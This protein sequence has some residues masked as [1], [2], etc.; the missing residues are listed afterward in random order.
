MS[1]VVRAWVAAT[2]VLAVGVVVA[3]SLTSFASAEDA[4]TFL[5]TF[6]ALAVGLGGLTAV[7]RAERTLGRIQTAERQLPAPDIGVLI[8]S[9]ADERT[10][11]SVARQVQAELLPSRSERKRTSGRSGSFSVLFKGFGLGRSS[12]R[13]AEDTEVFENTDDTNVLLGRVLR[14]LN[15]KKTLRRDLVR[16]PGLA[17][18]PDDRF[19][20]S[21]AIAAI[22]ENFVRSQAERGNVLGDNLRAGSMVFQPS[23]GDDSEKPDR[24][25]SLTRALVINYDRFGEELSE[26][27]GREVPLQRVADSLRHRWSQL[28]DGTLV[29]VEG[30]WDIKQTD[31][32][33]LLELAALTVDEGEDSPERSVEMPLGLAV[34]CQV[35]NAILL[36][37]RAG[38]LRAGQRMTLGVFGQVSRRV[39]D[40]G[41]TLVL[42]PTA[43]FER[44]AAPS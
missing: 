15:D 6:L 10:L 40:D 7:G 25:N 14:A 11:A 22:F 3:A 8:C 38:R 23:L 41:H 12:T 37:H 34:E 39:S 44:L 26:R 35:P 13:G 42:E 2:A 27:L 33:L 5:A 19:E 28:A 1:G 21:Q 36:K 24:E 31:D 30:P 4:A 29:L 43:V 32:G 16:I 9:A 17:L 18:E 20:D